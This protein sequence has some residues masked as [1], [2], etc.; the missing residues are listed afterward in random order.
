MCAR[1]KGLDARADTRDLNGQNL[2]LCVGAS[3][4][5]PRI[6]RV[7]GRDDDNVNVVQIGNV[8]GVSATNEQP[9]SRDNDTR[10]GF[11]ERQAGMGHAANGLVDAL[12]DDRPVGIILRKLRGDPVAREDVVAVEGIEGEEKNGHGEVDRHGHD[13]PAGGVPVGPLDDRHET[14]LVVTRDEHAHD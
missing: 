5:P 11:A 9:R 1:T 6:G 2:R 7:E 8:D 3:D 12:G 13:E 10:A 14:W 4:G